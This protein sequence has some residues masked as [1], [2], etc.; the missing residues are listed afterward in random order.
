MSQS[1]VARF[2]RLHRNEKSASKCGCCTR[3]SSR[4]ETSHQIYPSMPSCHIRGAWRR[5]YLK[6]SSCT[7]H[8]LGQNWGFRR[9][10][11]VAKWRKETDMTG[12]GLTLAVLTKEAAQSCQKP[13]TRCTAGTG[14]LR[15]AT[16]ISKML[17]GHTS[18]GSKV[19]AWVPHV[20]S[21]AAGLCR[22]CLLLM[23]WNSTPAIGD[24]SALNSNLRR[25]CSM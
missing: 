1:I 19:Q 9:F 14:M 2:R 3:P 16:C 25:Y 13:S 4:S 24:A 21:H 7:N 10:R 20:R 18:R 5:C 22:S 8:R 17:F 23:C 12:S 15:F 6:K 11:E